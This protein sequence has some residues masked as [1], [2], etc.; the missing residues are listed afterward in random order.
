MLPSCP[1]HSQQVVDNLCMQ[2][3][4]SYG[5]S[6]EKLGKKYDAT[7]GEV[8]VSTF[9]NPDANTLTQ[10]FHQP[11][12]STVLV[13]ISDLSLNWEVGIYPNPVIDAFRLVYAHPESAILKCRLWNLSGQLM[14]DWTLTP[15]DTPVYCSHLAPGIYLLE[16]LDPASGTKTTARIVK[17]NL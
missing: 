15:S 14:T 11:E 10:G 7:L 2:V 3:I 16:M 6:A 13:G 1:L 17:T 12:C 5:L 9:A 8:M 4:G